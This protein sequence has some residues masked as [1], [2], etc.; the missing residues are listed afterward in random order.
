VQVFVIFNNLLN[1]TSLFV[2]LSSFLLMVLL[3]V[4]IADIFL[5]LVYGMT[6]YHNGA[7]MGSTGHNGANKHFIKAI[8]IVDV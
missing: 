6:N 8:V 3:F 7:T 4:L 1:V 5:L 2:S